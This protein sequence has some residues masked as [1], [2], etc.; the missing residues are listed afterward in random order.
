MKRLLWTAALCV[1]ALAGCDSLRERLGMPTSAK[2]E[3][4]VVNGVP[5]VDPEPLTFHRER[6]VMIKWTLKAGLPFVF[7]DADGIRIDGEDVPGQPR[8]PRQTEIVDCRVVAGGKQFQCLNKNSLPGRHEY[9]YTVRLKGTDGRI[10]E[11]DPSIVN[12]Q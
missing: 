3:V 5:T 2:P 11:K 7:V 8:N 9:K 12:A 6:N 10:I 1:F 4:D